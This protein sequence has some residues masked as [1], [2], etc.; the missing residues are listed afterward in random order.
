M[1]KCGAFIMTNDNNLDYS[2]Y[3]DGSTMFGY[4]AFLNMI[5]GPRGTGKS[6]RVKKFAIDNYIRTG[7]KFLYIR[8]YKKEMKKALFKGPNP[9]FFKGLVNKIPKYKKMNLTNNYDSF[10]MGKENPETIG[11]TSIL[12]TATVEKS[13]EFDDVN[14][15][16]FDEYLIVGGLYHYLKNEITDCFLELVESVIRTRNGKIILLGNS[17]TVFN[18]YR[19]YFNI[20]EGKHIYYDKE[21]NIYYEHIINEKFA[22]YKETTPVGRL[23]KGTAYGNYNINNDFLGDNT[24][25]IQQKPRDS[26][27]IFTIKINNMILGIWKLNKYMY[28]TT[29]YNPNFPIMFAFSKDDH[30]ENTILEKRKTSSLIK[31]ICEKYNRGCLFFENQIIKKSFEE[32]L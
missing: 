31:V 9:V 26:K 6:F 14:L 12:S 11:Y 4:N 18:P 8:R 21:R 20:P 1:L 30:D 17:S 27:F 16:I 5:D 10:L 25:F 19:M 13:G 29:E 22:H 28:V 2:M 32:L 15:V 3:W 23:I 7:G 24:N